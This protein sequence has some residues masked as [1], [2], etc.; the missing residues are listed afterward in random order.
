MSQYIF[1]YARHHCPGEHSFDS[2]KEALA[3]AHI[4]HEDNLLY[5]KC[6]E[7]D[8]KVILDEGEILQ[9]IALLEE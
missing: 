5:P 1:K 6:I 4:C 2:L 8:G 9:I 7:K 3:H